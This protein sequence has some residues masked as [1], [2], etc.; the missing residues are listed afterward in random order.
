VSDAKRMG[1]PPLGDGKSRG[2]VFT[3][4]LTREERD[5]I[6][7]AAES[8]GKAVTQWARDVLVAS[9]G[10]PWRLKRD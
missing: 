10:S 4:R 6:V 2:V 5:T 3:L 7:A 8:D 1:R 9:A